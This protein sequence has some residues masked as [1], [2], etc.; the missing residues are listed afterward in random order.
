MMRPHELQ[1]TQ[2]R[3]SLS[4]RS[5]GSQQTLSSIAPQSPNDTQTIK[6]TRAVAIGKP[7]E[8]NEKKLSTL[9]EYL[10][11]EGTGNQKLS[12]RQQPPSSK[13]PE[14]AGERRKS[15]QKKLSVEVSLTGTPKF[16]VRQQQPSS[17]E[18]QP[19]SAGERR[20]SLK[21]KL[22]IEV[23]LPQNQI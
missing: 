2:K 14:S 16:S 7:D 22:S 13:Q 17:V 20:K 23:A 9:D 21:K 3:R 12:V 18:S 5:N 10:Q 4:L 6:K 8:S 1:K 11:I 15:L 19:E